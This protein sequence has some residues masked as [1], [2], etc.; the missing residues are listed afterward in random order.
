MIGKAEMTAE[1]YN[2]RFMVTN[3]PAF[4]FA[5]EKDPSRFLPQRLYEETFPSPLSFRR[6]RTNFEQPIPKRSMS[7]ASTARGSLR[8]GMHP[9][10]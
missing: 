2:P 10:T 7:F 8:E 6:Q 9:M 1:G 5:Q 4:G 3:L